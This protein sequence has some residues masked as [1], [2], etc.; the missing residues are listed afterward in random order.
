M[1]PFVLSVDVLPPGGETFPLHFEP[2]EVNEAMVGAGWSGVA[3][4]GPLDA[5]ATAM[6]SGS[7]TF[8]IGRLS[9]A[10]EYECSRC[11][12]AFREEVR[13]EF[14][15]TFTD[16]EG[17]AGRERELRSEDLETEALPAREIDLS[18]VVAEE[19]F[20]SLRPYPA[21]RE[22]CRGLCQRCGANLND[23]PCGCGASLE[24]SP[25]AKLA[26]WNPGRD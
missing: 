7:D 5:T 10:V 17:V 4:A 9:V 13:G 6:R 12:A 23:A 20:L 21:C 25:F 1:R 15:R 22:D 19:L 18:R 2:A 3:A 16:A 26:N 8:V 14:H 24:G 11:L